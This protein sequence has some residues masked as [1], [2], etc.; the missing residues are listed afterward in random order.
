MDGELGAGVE[1]TVTVTVGCG[2]ALGVGSGDP[3]DAGAVDGDGD[4][5]T[6]MLLEPLD[7]E[8]SSREVGDESGT[9]TPP[10]IRTLRTATSAET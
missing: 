4:G 2:S 8:N 3:V 1:V 6:V 5:V 9:H 7:K 10:P